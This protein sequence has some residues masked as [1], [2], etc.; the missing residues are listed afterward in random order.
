MRRFLTLLF[1]LI[2]ALGLCIGVSAADATRASSVN[3]FA[4][5]S[6]DG[7]CEVTSTVTLHVDTPQEELTYPV[8]LSASNITLNGSPVL[9]QKTDQARLVDL[10]KTLG[11]M[12]GDFSFTVG[13]SIHSAVDPVASESTDTEA[14]AAAKKLQL[15][16]PLLAGFAY[17]IDQLQFSINLP[18][19]LSQNPSFVS[20]YHQADIEK[21]LT[22][23]ISG[24]NI[25]GRSWTSLKDHETL[26]MYL[27]A[28]EE[29]FPQTRAEL[30]E[31]EGVTTL[32][33]ICA[34]LALLYWILFL[35]NF[36][37]IRDFPA[38]APEGMGAGQMGTV[39]MMAGT[40]LSLMIFSWAQLGYVILRMDRRGRVFVMKRMEMG[41]ERTAFEQACFH[42]LF[43]RKDMVDT[44]SMA[45]QRL[46]QS[47]RLQKSA[48]QL[49]RG[50]GTGSIKIFRI[51]MA[52][53]GLLSG[54][55]F[56]ILL[57]N[58][59]DYGWFFMLV[60]SVVGLICSWHIQFWPEGVFLHHRSRIWV[61]GV[62]CV[63][64]LALGIAIGQFGLALLAVLL[65]VAAGFLAAFGGR[66]SEEGRT[67]MGQTL[68]LRRYFKKLSAKQIQQMCH[69]NPEFFFDM[70]PYAIALGCDGAFSRRFGKSRLPVCPY[71]QVSNARGMTAQ[72]WCQLMRNLLDGMTARQRKMPLE[73][74]RSVM[75]NYMK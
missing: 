41:N 71:I 43:S 57:G 74:L 37:P 27:V 33:G 4:T 75:D 15:E 25:A 66:R 49:W 40:D 59:L 28:T 50:K 32:I 11:G 30:P 51:I 53:A 2:L 3:L 8:P 7:S 24:G 10:S 61:A 60:L 13:Y 29:M 12:S 73:A 72:Q 48:Q 64:W 16:L 44:A 39:L 58:M 19:M 18:G 34:G 38:V 70:A 36:L 14:E 46:C 65:Q 26:T 9:T 68:R 20:G 31:A 54:T 35:R 6:S 17:P 1:C 45:F 42:K 47:V 52:A 55:C 62:L 63:L 22:Y 23:S 69:D 21:D 56:G 67:A 5:V